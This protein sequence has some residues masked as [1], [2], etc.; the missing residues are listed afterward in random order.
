MRTSPDAD[1]SV[2]ARRYDVAVR[3]DGEAVD[4]VRVS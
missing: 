2:F 3:E 1:C 4:K